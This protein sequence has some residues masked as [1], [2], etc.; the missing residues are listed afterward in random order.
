ME[1]IDLRLASVREARN[2]DRRFCFEV[3]TPQYK[4]VYQATSEEDM[5]SWIT[6][7]NNALQSAVEGRAFKDK[8]STAHGDSGLNGVDIG[9][10]LVGKSSS[11]SHASHSSS[12]IPFRRTTVGARPNTSR[13]ASFEE[14]PD[15]LLQMLRENDQGNCWC[16]ECGSS[17]KVEW[18]SLNLAIIVCIECSGIHRSLGTH[19]SKIRSLTLDTTS[20]TPDIVELLLLVGNR[21]SNMVWEARLDPAMKL[22]PQAT[23]EQRFN[24]INAKYVNRAFVEP[25]SSTLS[26]FATADET[27]L[28]AIKRNEIQ[29][30]IYALALQANPNVTDKS[31][32]THAVYLA[33]AAAD[34]AP[35]SP[36]PPQSQASA[37]PAVDRVVPFPVAELLI[38]NGAEIPDALPQVPLSLAAQAY[39]EMKRGRKAAI[40]AS[41]SYDSPSASGSTSASASALSSSTPATSA[42]AD[43]NGGANSGSKFQ[44][45]REARLQ[46]RVSAGGRLAKSPIPE[47]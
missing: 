41:G 16:A 24:F 6:A 14:R 28:A 2:A 23:R 18:V 7:I 22:T 12:A 26:R 1:P 15:K 35:P 21:V 38:Q 25:I 44:R 20:F 5:H 13:G 45:D 29:Q 42:L 37:A 33:L 17:N 10:M 32:G 9:S 31:R 3:I 19:V 4:R 30:I 27:L 11:V 34:P 8:P 39:V 47:R 36:I 46:K 43:N 40:E